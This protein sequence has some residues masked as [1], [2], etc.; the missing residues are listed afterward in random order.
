MYQDH[1]SE[2]DE[3]NNML[4]DVNFVAPIAHGCPAERDD[5]D[6]QGPS[7]KAGAYCDVITDGEVSVWCPVGQPVSKVEGR[8]EKECTSSPAV[9]IVQP[10]VRMTREET[11][12]VILAGEQEDEWELSER[13]E[14]STVGDCL[15]D[16]VVACVKVVKD[17]N[18]EQDR[19]GEDEKTRTKRW[20]A[21]PEALCDMKRG[22]GGVA[23]F[24]EDGG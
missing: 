5:P 13:D 17:E 8:G 2:S 16:G 22:R 4:N 14:P 1:D 9:K 10:F 6:E 12:E 19:L 21:K 11:D 20:D 18:N 7:A 23:D 15:E 24:A 3:E